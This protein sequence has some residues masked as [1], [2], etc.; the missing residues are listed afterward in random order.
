MSAAAEVLSARQTLV[1]ATDRRR[2]SREGSRNLDWQTS[3]R[4][5]LLDVP[6][7]ERKFLEPERLQQID[8][9]HDL[10]V[11]DS[12]IGREG[13]CLIFV[14]LPVAAK[15]LLN[16]GLGDRIVVQVKRGLPSVVALQRKHEW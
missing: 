13:N 6:C 3:K 12:S 14:E 15:H 7:V 2:R 16:V 8:H 5:S 11:G 4:L 9:L 1:L 10:S